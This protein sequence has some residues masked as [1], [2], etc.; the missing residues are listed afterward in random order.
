MAF[1]STARRLHILYNDL[2][3]FSRVRGERSGPSSAWS[4][5]SISVS[6]SQWVRNDRRKDIYLVH[7]IDKGLHIVPKE[8]L[9]RVTLILT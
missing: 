5:E 9:D 2:R 1:G 8:G 6:S 4:T 3:H 7:H